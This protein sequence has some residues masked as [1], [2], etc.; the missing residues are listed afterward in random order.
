MGRATDNIAVAGYG[1]YIDGK[2]VSTSGGTSAFFGA[3]AC[4]STVRLGVDAFDAAGNR[5]PR[6][7]VTTS[8]ASC[9]ARPAGVVC[10]KVAQPGQGTAAALLASLSS[11]QIGC[12][13]GGLYTASSV[14]VLDF[15]RSGVALVGYPGE[16]AVVRGIVVVRQGVDRAR[17]ADVVVEGTGGSNTIQVYGTDFVLEDS[18]ITNAWRGRSCLML[19]DGSAGTAVRPVIRRNRFHE[20]G[21]LANGNKDHAIYAAHVTDGRISEN[22]FWNT[23]AYSVHLYPDAQRTVVSHNTIDGGSPSVRGGIVFGGDG[24]EASRDNIVEYNVIAYAA[25]YNIESSWGAAIGTGNI[26]RSNCVWGGGA[27]NISQPTGFTAVGNVV[28]EPR[29][30]DR[31][32]RDYSLLSG[33]PCLG[34][35]Q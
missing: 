26:A 29:F 9:P 33:S 22:Q 25:T 11:G 8:T 17:L 18:D 19:G 3:L 27:G 13:R 5:S 15:T 14:H 31:S 21:S 30:A 28:A 20:C 7:D 6:V 35:I 2:R 1:L 10:D 16:R 34:V 23:A 12:L 32:S 24:N 4:G